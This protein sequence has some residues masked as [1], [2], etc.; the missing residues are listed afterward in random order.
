[1]FGI[2]IGKLVGLSVSAAAA[3]LTHLF[4]TLSQRNKTLD[5]VVKQQE[6][7]QFVIRQ[8]Q[9]MKEK[10]A[11]QIL[12]KIPTD[13]VIK[14]EAKLTAVVAAVVSKFPGIDNASATL[15]VKALL[16]QVGEGAAAKLDQATQHIDDSGLF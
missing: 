4:Y 6:V 3:G 10:A 16:A 9:A 13:K 14:G 11:E 5:R 15:L 7:E 8:I 1:M 2:L 12:K